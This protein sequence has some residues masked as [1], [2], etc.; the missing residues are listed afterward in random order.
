MRFHAVSD[1]NYVTK[2]RAIAL[3]IILCELQLATRES[4]RFIRAG[5]R[6]AEC[7]SHA[8]FDHLA[9][10]LTEHSQP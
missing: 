6:D 3:H 1:A 8:I 7:E 9:R 10:G 4:I 5:K 2:C